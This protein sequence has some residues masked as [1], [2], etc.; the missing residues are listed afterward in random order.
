MNPKAIIVAFVGLQL[1]DFF[2]TFL[3][4]RTGKGYEANPIIVRLFSRVKY[5]EG[6]CYIKLPVLP[7]GMCLANFPQFIEIITVINVIY[8][9]ININNCRILLK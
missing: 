4:I 7:I 3:L 1:L 6:L 5:I 9:C 8:I 2:L